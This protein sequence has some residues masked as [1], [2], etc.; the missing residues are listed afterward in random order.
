FAVQYGNNDFHTMMMMMLAPVAFAAVEFCRV[1]LALAVR[2]PSYG[3]LLKLVLVTGLIGAA[4]VTVKSVSQLGELM[5]RPRLHD[6][7][8]ARTRLTE[9][10]NALASI[11]TK[12]ADADKLALQRTKELETAEEEVIDSTAKLAE[13]KGQECAPI[14]GIGRNGKAYKRIRWIADPP[15][16]S[17]QAAA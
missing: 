3:F 12:I 17:L 6:V 9:A 10:E 4:F 2:M 14:S 8:K 16:E 13:I 7:A 5:F 1:P 15:A 11:E